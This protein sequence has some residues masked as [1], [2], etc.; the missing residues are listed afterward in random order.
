MNKESPDVIGYWDKMR[1]EEFRVRGTGFY[2]IT[3]STLDY[4]ED[5]FNFPSLT[6]QSRYMVE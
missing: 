2:A 4:G 1:F 5:S 3:E 6:V